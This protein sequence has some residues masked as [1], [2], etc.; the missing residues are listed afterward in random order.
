MKNLIKKALTTTNKVTRVIGDNITLSANQIKCIPHN[1]KMTESDMRAYASAKVLQYGDQLNNVDISFDLPLGM[2][3]D[4]S[5]AYFPQ[6]HTIF[7]PVMPQQLMVSAMMLGMKWEVYVDCLIAHEMGHA[8]DPA[9]SDYVASLT[10]QPTVLSRKRYMI[11]NMMELEI[12]AGVLGEQFAK[13]KEAFRAFDKHNQA[14]YKQ[15]IGRLKKS[16]EEE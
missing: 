8:M 11:E 12:T 6:L 2:D 3:I 15:I 5:A 14:A 7:V 1:L 16:T 13:D 10:K 9:V 4:M